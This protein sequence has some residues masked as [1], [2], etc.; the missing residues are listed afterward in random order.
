MQQQIDLFRETGSAT[1][2]SLAKKMSTQVA[3]LRYL[4][5]NDNR[6]TSPNQN[7]GRE[8][9][10]LFL[11]GVGNYTEADV[12]ASTAA[13]TGHTDNWET[14]AYVWRREWHDDITKYVP[15]QTINTRRRLAAVTATRRST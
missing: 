11:L 12:E 7:F 8:L 9:M 14:D 13:W 2:A 4:D 6:K 10:E 5:N 15:R 1:C 3:M